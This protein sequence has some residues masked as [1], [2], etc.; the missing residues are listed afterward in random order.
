M[1]LQNHFLI[2]MPHLEDEYFNRSVVYIC[3]HNEQGAMGLV[4]TRPTDLSIAELCAKMNFMMADNR[5]YPN[6]LVLAGG[7]TN[8]ERGFIL[9]TAAPR[10]FQHSYKVTDNLYLTTSADVIDSF[11]TPLAPHKYLVALGCA[12]WSPEQLEQEIAN[13]DWL[14]APANERILFDVPCE[15]RWLEANLLLGIHNHNFAYQA[16]HC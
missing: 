1:E 7:P 2:A 3:E 14:I 4:L 11:G 5:R 13:N 12:S 15:E 6:E 16:G 10:P 8:L 9:H